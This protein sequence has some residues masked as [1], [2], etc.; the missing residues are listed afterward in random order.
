MPIFPFPH[1]SSPK[2]PSASISPCPWRR[3][4]DSP[5]ELQQCPEG[6]QLPRA[7]LEDF[8][9]CP[10]SGGG[11]LTRLSPPHGLHQEC[12]GVPCKA[13]PPCNPS[14]GQGAE[15]KPFNYNAKQLFFSAALGTNSLPESPSKHFPSTIKFATQRRARAAAYLC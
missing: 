11:T 4:A 8:W 2:Q 10:H 15:P 14:P 13:T 3:A 5:T 1:L 12:Q 7:I 6:L 9:L